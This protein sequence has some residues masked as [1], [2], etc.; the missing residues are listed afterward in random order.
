[1]A[2]INGSASSDD[3]YDQGQLIKEARESSLRGAAGKI[4]GRKIAEDKPRSEVRQ[5]LAAYLITEENRQYNENN[6]ETCQG[7]AIQA[8]P[9][10]VD[11]G[12]RTA[13]MGINTVFPLMAIGLR[14]ADN[15][16]FADVRERM[17]RLQD[18]NERQRRYQNQK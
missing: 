6:T 12:A 2:R 7:Q 9:V 10:A 11:T 14:N 17:R 13:G 5:R 1:M 18:R 3:G 15:I 16:S 4:G 8:N